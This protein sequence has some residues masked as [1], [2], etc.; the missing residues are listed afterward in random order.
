MFI[1]IDFIQFLKDNNII[2]SIISI[3]L[4]AK[5]Q[6]LVESMIEH[7]IF[8]ILRRDID[9]D[10]NEDI[11]ELEKLNIK[12]SGIKIEIGKFLISLIRYLLIIILI[13]IFQVYFKIK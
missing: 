6:E 9:D 12:F 10:G 1:S 2:G 7:L 3:M 13:Y 4:G 8:P 11:K 5:T